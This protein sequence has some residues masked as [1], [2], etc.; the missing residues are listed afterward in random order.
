MRAPV[1]DKEHVA[2]LDEI[3]VFSDS[4]RVLPNEA[5]TSA[6]GFSKPLLETPRAVSFISEET[7][8]LFGLSA[9][10]DLVR[11]VPGTFTTTRFG[12]QGS[13]DVRNVPA[14]FYF[15]G[16]KRLSLQGH[17]RSVLGAID[18]IEVVRGPPSPIFGMGKIGGYI[19]VDADVRAR[20]ERRLYRRSR[21]VSCKAVIGSYDRNEWSFGVGGPIDAVRVEA[22]RLLP[23]RP[24]RRLGAPS[25]AACPSTAAAAGRGQHR[26]F[27]SVR[28]GSSSAPTT[29]SRA[30]R[31]R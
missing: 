27:R 5:S 3:K 12:I 11:L 8:D 10:E 28:C 13:V 7:I 17:G 24:A 4:R 14:D 29:S 21:R 30:P 31:A 20:E 23:L 26:R 15:R 18:T 16:M 22:G 9:V 1:R 19:N 6:F 2:R 25:R